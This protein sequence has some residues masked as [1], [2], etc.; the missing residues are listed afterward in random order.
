MFWVIEDI[1]F[2]LQR[3][4]LF[5]MESLLGWPVSGVYSNFSFQASTSIEVGGSLRKLQHRKRSSTEEEE[6]KIPAARMV[7]LVVLQL[8]NS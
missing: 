2:V 5:K 4:P 1:D 6:A 3:L 8:R 7:A